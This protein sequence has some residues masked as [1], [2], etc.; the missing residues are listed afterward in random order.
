ML[1]GHSLKQAPEEW[2]RKTT[3]TDKDSGAGE[4]PSLQTTLVPSS[5]ACL[6]LSC[7]VK[8]EFLSCSFTLILYG[9]K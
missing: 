5:T 1:L 8:A 4:P 6:E 7:K 2:L 9:A 3:E